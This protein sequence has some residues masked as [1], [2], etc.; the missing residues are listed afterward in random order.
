MKRKEKQLKDM[1]PMDLHKYLCVKIH[2][3]CVKKNKDY[4]NSVT[5]TYKKYGMVAYLVQMEDKINRVKSLTV[6]N[7]DKLVNDES[8]I[9]SLI[10]LSN[11]ALLA[12]ID[13]IKEG[14]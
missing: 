6:D 11:Y 2:D 7:N 9:N 8:V 3:T 12:A 5:Q 13:L 10:D 1:D 14:E 4:G